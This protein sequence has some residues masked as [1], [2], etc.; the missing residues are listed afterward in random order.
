MFDWL[1]DVL[2]SVTGV[3]SK[4][5]EEWQK[6]KTLEVEIKGKEQ[7]RVYDLQL[8]QLEINTRL[9]EQGIKVEA[10]WDARA[11]EGMKH[12]WKDEYFLILMTLPLIGCFI[13][14]YQEDVLKGFEILEKT[15]F[16]YIC[17]ILGMLAGSWGLRWLISGIKGIKNGR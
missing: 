17:S 9:A 15:P 16:W 8:K 4:P 10:D 3:I 13:P 5:L 1:K 11:Q 7:E 14:A 2:V 12:S 6:R